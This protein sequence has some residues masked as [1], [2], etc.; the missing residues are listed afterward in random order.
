MNLMLFVIYLNDI[1]NVHNKF[2]NFNT[3]NSEQISLKEI[4]IDNIG[5]LCKDILVKVEGLYKQ[6]ILGEKVEK[7]F[8][9][10]NMVE[11]ELEEFLARDYSVVDNSQQN[12]FENIILSIEKYISKG[13][14]YI[15]YINHK[16]ELKIVH[17]KLLQAVKSQR[18]RRILNDEN[19]EFAKNKDEYVEIEVKNIVIEDEKLLEILNDLYKQYVSIDELDYEY[20]VLR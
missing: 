13:E 12:H 1:N 10:L 20:E 3:E 5:N 4:S 2:D 16:N 6:L 17:D 9:K 15:K 18:I 7:S 14:K 19:K 11:K 8:S